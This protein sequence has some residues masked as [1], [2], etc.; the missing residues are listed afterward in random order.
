MLLSLY[1][2]CYRG[3]AQYDLG[4]LLLVARSRTAA[5]PLNASTW[6]SRGYTNDCSAFT[7]ARG[8]RPK[9]REQLLTHLQT[10][11]S[12]SKGV[13]KEKEVKEKARAKDEAKAS[14]VPMLMA[15][16]CWTARPYECQRR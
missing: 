1:F 15:R 8:A 7:G 2:L 9:E 10:R 14:R 3:S 4:G 6:Y 16:Q 5:R 13:V 12:N 11:A